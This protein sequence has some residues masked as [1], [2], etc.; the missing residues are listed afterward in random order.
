[1]RTTQVYA[2]CTTY[3]F[4]RTCIDFVCMVVNMLNSPDDLYPFNLITIYFD[5]IPIL[6]LMFMLKL[7]VSILKDKN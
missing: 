2:Y 1:V 6:C 4:V 7:K 3:I 5:N